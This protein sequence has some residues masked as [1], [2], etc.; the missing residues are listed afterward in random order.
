SLSWLHSDQYNRLFAFDE[1]GDEAADRTSGPLRRSYS[2]ANR[3]GCA[4]PLSAAVHAEAGSVW[5]GCDRARDPSAEYIRCVQGAVRY[6]EAGPAHRG[7]YARGPD[8]RYIRSARLTEVLARREARPWGGTPG[9]VAGGWGDSI[10]RH[11]GRDY[12]DE[13]ERRPV[14]ALLCS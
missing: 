13:S 12:R 14:P 10:P 2:A 4:V 6:G 3:L 7:A 11:T 9:C 1:R 5:R 8:G